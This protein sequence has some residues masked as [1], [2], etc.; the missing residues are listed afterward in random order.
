MR[1]IFYRLV[2]LCGLVTSVEAQE[3]ISTRYDEGVKAFQDENYPLAVSTLEAVVSADPTYRDA[4]LILARAYQRQGEFTR[5]LALFTQRK[6][7]G[8][9]GDRKLDFEIGVV[10]F[11]QKKYSEAF[12]AFQ[13]AK[14]KDPSDGQ[15][16][17]YIGYSH[18]RD[19]QMRAALSA[20][21][22]AE[23]NNPELSLSSRYQR[24]LI[25]Y[26]IGEFDNALP[27]LQDVVDRADDPASRQRASTLAGRIKN[28]PAPPK[29]SGIAMLSYQYDDNVNVSPDGVDLSDDQTLEAFSASRG[30]FF[31][32]LNAT[33]AR[34]PRWTLIFANTLYS[35]MHQD[36][37]LADIHA[38]D[39]N[40]LNYTTRLRVEHPLEIHDSR[41]VLG[42]AGR[43][44]LTLLG[45]KHYSNLFGLGATLEHPRGRTGSDR[46]SYDV[47]LEDFASA[48]NAEATTE[49]RDYRG[50]SIGYT[51]VQQLSLLRMTISATGR[52]RLED[53]DGR[54]FE[55]LVP[56]AALAFSIPVRP[57][58]TVNAQLTLDYFDYFTSLTNRRDWSTT[59][60][61]GAA[62]RLGSGIEA[63]VNIYRSLNR[64]T[65]DRDPGDVNRFSYSRTIV[66]GGITG[67]F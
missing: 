54:N 25:Y 29:V 39:F 40:L 5:A 24:A 33:L 9:N 17:Y 8:V 45:E 60:A 37:T 44:G 57:K 64:S 11:K 52:I 26:T 4:E 30:V 41:W 6:E 21:E 2:L 14:L 3:A 55:R 49:D 50:Q 36:R 42:V 13:R 1:S 35:S 19:H 10:L 16:D 63:I 43:F 62:Y 15:I 51:R 7:R 31:G 18:R 47:T 38:Y 23:T 53:S 65:Y 34:K 48:T 61:S 27:L 59:F 22:R 28:R 58:I 20:F 67:R 32:S 66:S 46:V 56:G 12:A